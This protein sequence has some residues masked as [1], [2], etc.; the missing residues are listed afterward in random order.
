[1]M[2]SKEYAVY[3]MTNAQYRV[4]STGVTNN[5]KRRVYEHI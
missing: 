1:M 4:L 5:Q 2:A 3:I